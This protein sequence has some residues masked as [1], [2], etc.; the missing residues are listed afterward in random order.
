VSRTTTGGAAEEWKVIGGAASSRAGRRLEGV[1]VR[2]S[3]RRRAVPAALKNVVA[4]AEK[5]RP[6]GIALQVRAS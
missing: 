2:P 5:T 4:A 3:D 1:L 6:Y